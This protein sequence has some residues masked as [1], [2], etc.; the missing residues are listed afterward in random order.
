VGIFDGYETD[1]GDHSYESTYL[2]LFDDDS[3]LVQCFDVHAVLELGVYKGGSLRA[4]RDLFLNAHIVGMDKDLSYMAY[5][6]DRITVIYG[7]V[8]NAADLERVG[9]LGRSAGISDGYDLIVDDASHRPIDQFHA[10][11][12]LWQF[13]LK[14]GF[15]VIE[16]LDMNRNGAEILTTCTLI[17]RGQANL[18]LHLGDKQA[19]DLLI[20]EKTV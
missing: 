20:L 18:S 8:R 17:V 15:Y 11:K 19:D 6:E 10:L 9:R 16:D 14:G 2:S 1:K 5:S 13:L 4:W 12:V 3:R 7:D